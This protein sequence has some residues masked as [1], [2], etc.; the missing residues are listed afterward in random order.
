MCL[1]FTQ[2]PATRKSNLTDAQLADFYDSNKDG[3]G[4]M[5]AKDNVLYTEKNRGTV[6]DWIAFYRKHEHRDAAFHLRMRTHGSFELE[7]VHPYPVAGFDGPAKLPLALMHN[8]ILNTGNAADTTKSDTWHYIRD[9]IHPL[10]KHSGDILFTTQMIDI[11]GKH[12][13]SSNKF[14]IMDA[15]GRLAVVNKSAGVEWNGMWFSNTYAWDAFNDQ[16]YPGRPAGKYVGYTGGSYYSSRWDDE[17]ADF[18]Q[19]GVRRVGHTNLTAGSKDK[20]IL[21]KGEK[22]TKQEKREKNAKNPGVNPSLLDDL[23]YIHSLL[24]DELKRVGNRV[25]HTERSRFLNALGPI[26]AE[27]ILEEAV[28]GAIDEDETVRMMLDP[29]LAMKH[30]GL[31]VTEGG[32]FESRV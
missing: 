4:V 8:G 7:N 19:T 24:E 14:A 27:Q 12:I 26:G 2:T 31:K 15:H 25:S 6:E 20:E 10:I 18:H 1:L 23:A 17:F 29:V 21:V 9:F 3:F 32:V 28:M 13:G 22:T 30:L 5:Y 16:L 11:L